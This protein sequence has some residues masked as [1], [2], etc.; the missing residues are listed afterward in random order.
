MFLH[1]L[2]LLLFCSQ[3][4]RLD[5]FLFVSHLKLRVC[6]FHSF[7][8]SAVPELRCFFRAVGLW[9]KRGSATKKKRKERDDVLSEKEVRETQGE[10]EGGEEDGMSCD[11]SV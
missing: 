2:C 9:R 8:S 4:L 11:C 3:S 6:F 5:C 1:R 7:L 10:K